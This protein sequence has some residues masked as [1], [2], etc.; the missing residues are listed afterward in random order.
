MRTGCCVHS[1]IALHSFQVDPKS[2]T[3]KNHLRS[4]VW[5]YLLTFSSLLANSLVLWYC[6]V[7]RDFCATEAFSPT[8]S[9][10]ALIC[11]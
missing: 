2:G 3:L 5:H 7:K 6:D 1:L 10:S 9:C 4:C 8:L 11:L